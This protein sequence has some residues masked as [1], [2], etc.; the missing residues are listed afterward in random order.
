M[1]VDQEQKTIPAIQYELPAEN[2]EFLKKGLELIDSPRNALDLCTHRV[3]LTL[4]KNCNQLSL[5]E[6][7]KLAVM[8]LNCQLE[9]EGRA[10]FSCKPEM[11]KI[12]THHEEHPT[13]KFS[14]VLDSETMHDGHE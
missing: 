7:G 1:S 2:E 11:V 14:I 12:K 13:Q 4:K 9:I 6:I 8:M 3:V 10:T 5:E